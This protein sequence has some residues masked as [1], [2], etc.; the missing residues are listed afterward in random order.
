MNVAAVVTPWR[1]L[2]ALSLNSEVY[3]DVDRAL[4]VTC[5]D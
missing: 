1:Y 4:P 3:G 5:I 2:G